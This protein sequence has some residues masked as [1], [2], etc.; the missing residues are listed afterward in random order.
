M[1]W[2]GGNKSWDHHESEK[3]FD[4]FKISK[5]SNG[6]MEKMKKELPSFK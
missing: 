1:V 6:E 5:V 3:E 2:T 4:P